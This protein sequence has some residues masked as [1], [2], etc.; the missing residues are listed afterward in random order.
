M[1][2]ELKRL[3]MENEALQEQVKDLHTLR[4]QNQS[5]RE[6]MKAL[7]EQLSVAL[8][9]IEALK[10][11]EPPAFVKPNG[12]KAKREGPRKKRAKEH[13]GAR[14]R[15]M[16]T[17]IEEHLIRTCPDCQGDLSG[18]NISRRRQIVELPPPPPMEI[19]EYRVYK[20]WCPS[21]KKWH[22]APFELPSGQVMGQGRL[23][24]RISSVIAYLRTVMRLPIRQV[25]SYLQTLHGLKV[26]VGEI[27]EIQHRMRKHTAG[28]VQQLKAQVRASPAVQ[29]DET[30]WRENGQNGYVWSMNTEAIRYYEYHHSRGGKVV[31]ELLGETYE[32]VLGSDFYAGYNVHLGWHQRCWVHFLRDIHDLKKRH[33]KN[34]ELLTWGKEV[35]DIYDRAVAYQGPDP[36]LPVV[37]QE[38]ARRAQQRAF[39]QELW[40]VC[41]PFAHSSAP[42]HTLC[43]RVEQFLPELFVFVAIP[44]VPAHNN[45]AERSVRPLVI[46]RKI[47]G[48][49]RSP[50]GSQTRM[51]LFSLFS[52]WIAQGLD[53]F[54]QCLSLL[55]Q[56]S[57]SP[58]FS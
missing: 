35:K 51:A 3:R 55:S 5:L 45:L 56:P 53:P 30:G 44:G 19:T 15:E 17:R 27:V 11:K 9:Q 48:G 37:K 33:P 2:E 23:G 20:G 36:A 31:T 14:K 38:A 13:N 16:A 50:E 34:E 58:I 6:Q 40:A 46:A 25:Q 4:E 43:E 49:T 8:A 10:K 1:E 28:A 41:A 47:S 54:S 21:C 57:L 18:I 39:E 7:Q 52:T 29:A 24:V 12:N 26:S 32:G 22:E 42:M